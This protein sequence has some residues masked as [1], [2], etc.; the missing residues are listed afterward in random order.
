[1]K[2]IVQA[3]S[4]A[5][6]AL[7]ER[8]GSAG[9]SGAAVPI[10]ADIRRLAISVIGRALLSADLAEDD[11]LRFGQAVVDAL[12]L[13]RE[14]NTSPIN[15]PLILPTRRNRGLRQTREILDRYIDR[16]LA[17]R[18]HGHRSEDLLDALLQARDPDTAKRCD[19]QALL[20]ETKTLFVAGFETTATAV[21]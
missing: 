16:H 12:R 5:T 17:S 6:L 15:A 18:A 10:V 4:A 3:T 8:W 13:I 11:A 14:R 9:Q 19:H 21:A 7:M 1:V 20:D 2:R